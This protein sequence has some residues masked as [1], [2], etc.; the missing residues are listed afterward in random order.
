MEEL[1]VGVLFVGGQAGGP[2]AL[3]LSLELQGVEAGETGSGAGVTIGPA[4]DNRAHDVLSVSAVEL[5]E[6]RG[7]V[8]TGVVERVR[9]EVCAGKSAC[10]D[11]EGG[12][13]DKSHTL[14]TN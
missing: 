12:G 10:V 6:G 14:I 7:H 4:L 13:G 11:S 1:I 2:D 8:A 3:S 9:R 5:V